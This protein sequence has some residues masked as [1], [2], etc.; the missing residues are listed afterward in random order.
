MMRFLNALFGRAKPTPP[1]SPPAE[2]APRDLYAR[3]ADGDVVVVDVR[4]PDEFVGALGHIPA[5]LNRPL[6]TLGEHVGEL[7]AWRDR[8]IVVACLS[9]KRSARA[10][11]QLAAAGLSN[12]VLLRGG[13]Q[14][15]TAAGLPVET[16]AAP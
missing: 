5:S 15:W 4:N 11:E 16:G 6:P 1:G 3:L 2:I 7:S 12:L 9:D 13:M 8:T 14:A 10:I